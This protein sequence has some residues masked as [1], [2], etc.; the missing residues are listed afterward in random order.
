MIESIP[1]LDGL[2]PEQRELVLQLLSKQPAKMTIP[3]ESPI[4]R[5]PR[6]KNRFPV[7][8]T[9][10]RVWFLDQLIP[11]NL[12]YNI[13]L[14][15]RIVGPLN[16]DALQR[17][18][19]ELVRRHE[20][21]RTTFDLSEAGV[22]Q[23]IH[24]PSPL[25]VR[26]EDLRGR[27]PQE[28]E[29]MVRQRLS[30]E[31]SRPFD[32]SRGPL[33]RV[34]L[35]RLSENEQVLLV[36]IHHIVSDG[37]SNAIIIRELT[38]LYDA[39]L[40]GEQS[41]LPDLSLQYADYAVWQRQWVSA[42]ALKQQLDY[43]REQLHGLPEQE[44]PSDYPRPS[45]RSYRGAIYPFVFSSKLTNA[46][47]Q[48]NLKESVTMFMTLLTAFQILLSRYSGQKQFVVGT[49]IANRNRLDIEGVVGFF[50]NTL[51]LRAD[52]SGEPCVREL[53]ARVRRVC[54]DGQVHQ[55]LPFE[56]VV[57]DLQP[58]RDLSRNPLFQSMF[59]MQ[60]VGQSDESL[61]G[62]RFEPMAVGNTTVK[63]DLLLSMID[64]GESLIGEI[65]YATE[66][67]KPSTISRLASH[68][69][70]V[71]EQMV[72]NP[73]AR[74]SI[75]NLLSH[76]ERQ[77]AEIEWNDTTRPYREQICIHDLFE[78]Q[79]RRQPDRVATVFEEMELTYAELNRRA[80][81]L[82]HYLRDLGVGPGV[83]VA[84]CMDRSLEMVI[85]LIAIL[86]AGGAY[87]PIEP[88]FPDARIIWC[89]EAIGAKRVITQSWWAEYLSDLVDAQSR[90]MRL[91][92]ID[93]E[94]GAFDGFSDENP[95][96]LA[97][98][99]NVAYMI[100]TSGSTGAPKGVMVTHQPVVNLIE[101]V[102]RSFAV[103]SES[104]LLF[105][106]SLCF[107]L[108]VY[109]IFG[110]LS[111]GGS[112]EIAPEQDL[113][114]PRRLAERLCRPEITFWDSAPAALQQLMPFI[115]VTGAGGY[116]GL[117]LVFLSGDWIPVGL[118]DDIRNRFG[119]AEVIALGGAT[120]ATVWSNF[121]HVR[122]VD[123]VWSSIPYGRPIQNARYY[124]LDEAMQCCPPG[125][126]G[127]L[128]I[129]GECLSTG[130][131]RESV[132][133]A[134]SFV[135]DPFGADGKRIYRTGDLA[136]WWED[137]V[138]EFLGR[139]DDQVKIRGFRIELGEI[140]AV[141]NQHPSVQHAVVAAQGE[142]RDRKRLV[143]YLVLRDGLGAT[144]ADLRQHLKERLPNYM[145]PHEFVPL[146]SF[147]VTSNGKFDRKTLLTLEKGRLL[148]EASYVP[149][150]TPEEE[151][152][153]DIW[154][155]MLRRDQIG[156]HDNF[157]ELG[158]DSII[159]I[160]IINKADQAGLRLIP[161]DLFV[162]QTIAEL[163]ASKRRNESS[164]EQG[165][166]TGAVPLTPIQHWF[167][168]V[169]QPQPSHFNQALLLE[170]Q[171]QA[172]PEWLRQAVEAVLRHHDALRLRFEKL[173]DG[174]HQYHAVPGD[175]APFVVEELGAAVGDELVDAIERAATRWQQS[176]DLKVG[177]LM[178][179][180]QLRGDGRNWLLIVVHHLAI[181]GV[182]WLILLED[183]ESAYRQLR[184][185]GIPKFSLKTTSYQQ[186][187]EALGKY[188]RDSQE[189][190]SEAAYW[191]EQA[192]IEVGCLPRDF[193]EGRNTVGSADSLMVS[194]VEEETQV[195]LRGAPKA[196]GAQFHHLLLAALLEALAG[197][198]ADQSLRIDI[199]AHGREGFFEEIEVRRTI[200]WFTAIYPVVLELRPTS[201][202]NLIQSVRE[203]LARVPGSGFGYGVLRYLSGGDVA[204][205]LDP[206]QPAEVLFNYLGRVDQALGE[207]SIL[208]SAGYGSG[209]AINPLNLM[210]HAIEI[211]ASVEDSRLIARWTFSRNL[212]SK[213]TIERVASLF[214]RAL[215]GMADNSQQS[216]PAALNVPDVAEF[217][218]TQRDL[219]EI[220]AA[221]EGSPG[222]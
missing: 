101:W 121:Y 95:A 43:W 196:Y 71:L 130:Y 58:E 180:V 138:I 103:G 207:N 175:E 179:C 202:K 119:N 89:L 13:P 176:L 20:T 93:G 177:P 220:A 112:I 163:A 188:A 61:S 88:S 208:K 214:L 102:N 206:A 159:S 98:A 63:F 111:A 141:L 143:A 108:S 44:I 66:L 187:S 74:I 19:D 142:S 113:K 198:T 125:V 81:R 29:R 68:F 144:L 23:V 115:E 12:A 21:L 3:E 70:T 45:V 152:L 117:Q 168:E 26:V 161:R 131:F 194:L 204:R 38:T 92:P 165:M 122:V 65:E 106:T 22:E 146:K 14:A 129:G 69:Q 132:L 57:N 147:P 52:L 53:L 162:H 11:G 79:V 1:G 9:Q 77:R 193:P 118:P 99:Q 209:P 135:P 105:V 171:E 94:H 218:W 190:C 80:N 149:P 154:K 78:E 75:L 140:E 153:V 139:A 114:D 4:P 97:C 145:L 100:F 182:S 17:S 39:F 60:N 124:A 172:N 56:Q 34:V 5:Q 40:R 137:G 212:F 167:F 16:I 123:P 192:Q 90:S 197:W 191:I 10:Q 107:D 35:L 116:R 134:Q 96:P 87:V 156:V 169:E 84:V 183:L 24:S 185:G 47:R 199:E 178:R 59:V 160:Q 36:M 73:E 31:V 30:E 221:L 164:A 7:S 170:L 85:A 186:W 15:M 42:E 37:W 8:F 6:D 55:D 211:N 158:G 28:N 18:F 41:L 205:K 200:G 189:L 91:L 109:D 174:W 210:R 222:E 83:W 120:E 49:S 215:Q 219:D 62:L 213:T 86:K 155:E 150:R 195:L 76:E 184:Q 110:M 151:L 46:I 133:T 67:F 54:V 2:T 104:R 48:F 64:G 166:V 50:V 173:D 136:R 216:Q 148:P 82:A 126:P 51:A 217:G 72:C 128:Y 201:Q 32:L 181:D 157:F 25:P 127:Y 27:R 33:A 203:C